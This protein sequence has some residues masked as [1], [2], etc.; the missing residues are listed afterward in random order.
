MNLSPPTILSFSCDTVSLP[1]GGGPVTFTWDVVTDPTDTTFGLFISPDDTVCFP[2]SAGSVTINVVTPGIHTLTATNFVGSTTATVGP[3]T[4]ASSTITVNGQLFDGSNRPYSNVTPT[5]VWIYNDARTFSASVDVTS[6]T[7]GLFTFE[8]VPVPYNMA[9]MKQYGNNSVYMGLTRPDPQIVIGTFG[10]ANESMTLSGHFV[11]GNYPEL[12]GE[13]YTTARVY[14]TRSFLN[15]VGSITTTHPFNGVFSG[16][17]GWSGTQSLDGILSVIQTDTNPYAFVTT[18]NEY[19]YGEIPIQGQNG[20]TLSNLTPILTKAPTNTLTASFTNLPVGSTIYYAEL[21]II[22]KATFAHLLVGF[23]YPLSTPTFSLQLPIIPNYTSSL[24]LAIRYPDGSN[25]TINRNN[26]VSGGEISIGNWPIA[27][28]S[29]ILPANHAT[30]VSPTPFCSCTPP[31]LSQ[32]ANVL[33]QYFFY[34]NTAP[35]SLT[36]YSNSPSIQVPDLSAFSNSGGNL[37]P[38]YTYS[39]AIYCTIG[40]GDNGTVNGAASWFPGTYADEVITTQPAGSNS[41]TIAPATQTV[42]GTVTDYVGAPIAGYTPIAVTS[43][44]GVSFVN[45]PTVDSNGNFTVAN[46]PVPYN[47]YLMAG[48]NYIYEGL[49]IANPVVAWAVPPGGSGDSSAIS[50]TVSGGTYPETTGYSTTVYYT[51][52]NSPLQNSGSLGHVGA[53]TNTWSGTLSWAST[54]GSTLT[55]GSL[56][57]LQSHSSGGAWTGVNAGSLSLASVTSG[58][59]VTGEAISLSPAT[60]VGVSSAIVLPTTGSSAVISGTIYTAYR[61]YV[62]TGSSFP[63][64]LALQLIYPSPLKISNYLIADI[65]S[66]EVLAFAA[67]SYT[68]LAQSNISIVSTASLLSPGPITFNLPP[69]PF[70]VNPPPG[71]ITEQNYSTIFQIENYNLYS[72][73]PVVYLHFI[74]Q[75]GPNSD[76]WIYTNNSYVQLTNYNTLYGGATPLVDGLS[77]SYQ[78][79]GYGGSPTNGIDSLCQLGGINRISAQD[80]YFQFQTIPVKFTAQVNPQLYPQITVNGTIIDGYNN[81]IP[82]FTAGSGSYNYL[83]VTSA[84]G[85]SFIAYPKVDANGNFTVENCPATYNIYILRAPNYVYMGLTTTNPVVKYNYSLSL[86]GGFPPL[87]GVN[88]LGT[89][90]GG[91]YPESASGDFTTTIFYLSSEANAQIYNYQDYRAVYN[92]TNQYGGLFANTYGTITWSQAFGPTLTDGLFSAVQLQFASPGGTV[93]LAAWYGVQPVTVTN[94]EWVTTNIQLNPVSIFDVPY[95][96]TLPSTGFAGLSLSSPT[97]FNSYIISLE[98]PNN[99]NPVYYV[100][101]GAPSSSGTA[102]F[103]NIDG[104]FVVYVSTYAPPYYQNNSS[105]IVTGPIDTILGGV[106]LDVYPIQNCLSPTPGQSNVG[107]ATSFSCENYSMYSAEPVVYQHYIS[108]TSG[109]YIYSTYIFSPSPNITVPN[110]SVLY[111]APFAPFTNGHNYSYGTHVYGPTNMNTIAGTFGVNFPFYQAPGGFV[112]TQ[113]P[114]NFT[115]AV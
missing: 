54:L 59:P 55:G 23:I 83:A 46:C 41:I 34:S 87:Y 43:I 97:F 7:N 85:T 101:G 4:I 57:A 63:Q 26:L 5:T 71:T 82:N 16:T 64:P 73:E 40:N 45:Q 89:L 52:P 28:E 110:F 78:V 74:H 67:I 50:G 75:L 22:A 27:V 111:N 100:S 76:T 94:N 11:G 31:V 21:D 25:A 66:T 112:T 86:A 95:S 9:V 51:N 104:L 49:T 42:N 10:V 103:A 90:S 62:N 88:I 39:F 44:D 102:Y 115:T 84:D 30:G 19:W 29:N 60:M 77:Y 99:P 92:N 72:D 80:G 18:P 48:P 32:P 47:I 109:G 3:I 113:G 65:P 15:S 93:P 91:N 36:I 20:A 6:A 2:S 37:S 106:T 68:N 79:L 61:Y 14:P 53:G 8:D 70:Q 56:W 35:V 12:S 81:P 58:T 108:D 17:W 24:Y 107:Y 96:I 38:G 1:A 114:V 98:N 69:I 33:Y 13:Y 105:R